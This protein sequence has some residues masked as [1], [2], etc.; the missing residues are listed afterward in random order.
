MNEPPGPPLQEY[1][2]GHM[3]LLERRLPLAAA[4]QARA[5]WDRAPVLIALPSA[6]VE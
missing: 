4:L 2:I 5:E 3:L 6:R 1:V